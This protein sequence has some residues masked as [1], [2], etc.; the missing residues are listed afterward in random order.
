MKNKLLG[1]TALGFLVS[2]FL[3]LP[4]AP[5]RA[6]SVDERIKALEQELTRL[7]GEQ[8][9]LKKE[10]VAAAPQLPT[11]SYRPGGGMTITAADQSW[12]IRFMYE[13]N[14][15]MTWLEGQD[16]VRNGD[17]ELFGRRNRPFF[18]YF[19]D[20]GFY[21]FH[22]AMDMDAGDAT[23]IQRARYYIN[24]QQLNP[25]LPR[26]QFGMDVGAALNTYDQGS[27]ST[28]ATIEY[29][30]VRRDNGF[31]TGAHTGIG[32]EWARLP[33]VIFPGQWFFSYYWVIQG[34]GRADGD[35]DQSSK[36][37][38]VVWLHVQPFTESKIK[39]LSGLGMSVGAWFGNPD[40][41]NATN[42]NRRLRL[43]NQLGPNRLTLFDSGADLDRGL[44]TY[45]TPGLGWT[46]GPYKLMVSGGFDRWNSNDRSVGAEKAGRPG[47][48]GRIQGT[49]YK[50][51]NELFIWS[52]KGLLTGSTTTPNSLLM[53][54]SFERSWAECGRPNCDETV[55]AGGAQFSRNR[56]L[57]RELDFR[58]FFRPSLS[59][60]LAWRW[61]DASNVPT[62]TQ[63]VI[64]CSKNNNTQVGKDC[65]W[66][67]VALRFA[68]EW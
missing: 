61:Y 27:S 31:N 63:P 48:V 52:P 40:E 68:W 30:L 60:L 21:E 16:A 25:W 9:E 35:T 38:H 3:L 8:I 56:V 22:A 67:D 20:R 65:D 51:I 53:G 2:A 34:M 12:A 28:A 32:F 45:I 37:D 47:E 17:F 13:F 23:E 44:H 62:T 11:F 10:V 58:Y 43:R 33:G 1:M 6:D 54:W 39:W 41:R 4:L 29:P 55:T 42:S 26:F 50:I 14:M 19:W 24:L 57:V 59:M 15:D 5:A 18:I 7:K 46:V 49:F 36:S 64:G 66:H